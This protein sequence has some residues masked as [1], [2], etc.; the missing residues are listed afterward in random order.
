MSGTDK[1]ILSLFKEKEWGKDIEGEYINDGY[2][3][4]GK[5]AFGRAVDGFKEMMK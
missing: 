3:L 5:R 1:D 4:R 2:S